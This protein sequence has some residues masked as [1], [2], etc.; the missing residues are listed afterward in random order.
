MALS[1]PRCRMAK[2]IS[3]L[4]V[5]FSPS[6]PKIVSEHTNKMSTELAAMLVE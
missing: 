4:A 6:D 3:V 5:P 1:A 2:N